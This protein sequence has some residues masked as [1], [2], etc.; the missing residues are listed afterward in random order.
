MSVATLTLLCGAWLV[1]MSAFLRAF[2]RVKKSGSPVQVDR[3]ARVG[4]LLQAI[5]FFTVFF[6]MHREPLAGP[7]R[8]T[9]AIVFFASGC[10]LVHSAVGVLGR[11]WRVDA[12][13]NADHKLVREGAY[14]LV[15][16]PI[17][18]SMLCMLIGGGCLLAPWWRLPIAIALCI[19]GTEIRVRIEDG[20]L[21]SRFGEQFRQ[22]RRS[23]PAYLPGLR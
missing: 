1:W 20:L 14:R 3:R 10:A 2:L 8:Y 22:Y 11:Q 6:G 7:L 15:R 4:I 16:H 12:G 13:L 23:V 9:L 19:V 18:A 5:G 21:E 17:Y